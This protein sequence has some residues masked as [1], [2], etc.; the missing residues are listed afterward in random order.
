MST[1]SEKR[2]AIEHAIEI[3]KRRL[4]DLDGK[5]SLTRAE[6]FE[7][8]MTVECIKRGEKLLGKSTINIGGE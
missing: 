1:E 2:Q 5:R 6:T 3:A 4:K 8:D 7:R